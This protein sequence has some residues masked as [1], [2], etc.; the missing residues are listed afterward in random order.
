MTD[1]V[2]DLGIGRLPVDGD[3]NSLETVRAPSPRLFK[4]DIVSEENR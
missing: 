1:P 3:S 2:D 4:R